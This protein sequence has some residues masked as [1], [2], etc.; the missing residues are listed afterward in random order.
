MKPSFASSA[1]RSPQHL[2]HGAAGQEFPQS[3]GLG[4]RG[5]EAVHH[6]LLVKAQ[7][8]G[9]GHARGECAHH[10]GG[11]PVLIRGRVDGLADPGSGLVPGGHGL[12]DLLSALAQLLSQGEGG[13]NRDHGQVGDARVM[14]VVHVHHMSEYRVESRGLLHGHLC[15]ARLEGGSL[16]RRELP[17]VILLPDSGFLLGGACDGHTDEVF[18]AHFRDVH[19]VIAEFGN[20]HTAEIGGQAA[21]LLGCGFHEWDLLICLVYRKKMGLRVVYH[22]VSYRIPHIQTK[23][24]S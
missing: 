16:G 14:Y 6:L 15:E 20:V 9:G 24:K 21:G 12:D 3:G 8:F 23:G 17:G 11:M 19:R 5:A 18:D 10:S 4:A 7:K 1:E 22:Y 2:A 13:G